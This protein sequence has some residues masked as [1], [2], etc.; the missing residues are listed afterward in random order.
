MISPISFAGT[1]KVNNDNKEAFSK[2]QTYAL[3]KEME[4]GVSTRLRDKIIPRGRFGS[5][6]YKAEQTLIVPDEMDSDVETFCAN[7]GIKY[8]KYE[9]KDLLDPETIGDRIKY[10]PE[11]Y[12]KVKVDTKKLEELIQKQSSNIDHCKS[13]YD[14]YYKDDVD[15]MLKDGSKISTTTLIISPASGSMSC[16]PYIDAHGEKKLHDNQIMINFNQET[17]DPDHCVYF[18]LKDMGLDKIPVYVD[19]QTFNAGSELGLFSI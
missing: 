3:D 6:D 15:N 8:V 19:K 18:A 1:Y 7:N 12:R 14:K 5:F 4:D 2:F 17:D 11:G 9:T 10:P 16:K 13:D